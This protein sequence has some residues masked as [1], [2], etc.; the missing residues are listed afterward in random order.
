[1]AAAAILSFLNSKIFNG[2]NG[3]ERRTALA[4]HI[5]SRLLE[6]LPRCGY[7]SIF[8]DGGRRRL[9]FLKFKI[10]N[11]QDGQEGRTA[12]ACQISSNRLNRG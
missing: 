6:L 3:Q 10:F 4:C 5:S 11:G 12:S 2:Q 1:M 7:F 8:Q 9:G